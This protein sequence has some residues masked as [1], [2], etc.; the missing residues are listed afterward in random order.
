M[1][2]DDEMILVFGYSTS[3]ENVFLCR[4]RRSG[5]RGLTLHKLLKDDALV[6]LRVR[7]ANH[8]QQVASGQRT[9]WPNR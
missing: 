9:R 6:L 3:M 1:S 8:D 4:D 2:D 5:T 7:L